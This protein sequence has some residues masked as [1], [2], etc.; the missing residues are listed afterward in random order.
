[1][2]FRFENKETTQITEQVT[3]QVAEQVKRILSVSDFQKEYSTNELMSL[4]NLK[5][6]PTFLYQY[7]QPALKLNVIEMTIPEKPK[8]SK[9]RYKLTALGLELK[10]KTKIK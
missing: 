7:L 5:H 1:M 9:Q 6:R 3:E 10:K 2:I 8:S 4:L